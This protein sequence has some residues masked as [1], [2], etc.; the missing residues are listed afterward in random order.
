MSDRLTAA[1]QQLADEEIRALRGDNEK[2]RGI[3]RIQDAA[4]RSGTATLTAA[5]REAVEAALGWC[6]DRDT[7]TIATLRAL[8]ERAE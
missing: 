3:I 6:D 4:I 7:K 5:E 1:V 8:L 2:L